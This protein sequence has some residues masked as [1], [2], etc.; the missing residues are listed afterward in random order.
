GQR[1]PRDGTGY[2]ALREW[3]LAGAP[4]RSGPERE[5]QD[6]AVARRG[7]RLRVEAT[8]RSDAGSTVR[9]VTDLALF[10]ST[11]PTVVAVHAEGLL[12][13][14]GPGQP[15]VGAR[16]GT[17]T[18]LLRMVRPF[19]APAVEP[20]AAAHPLDAAWRAH[21]RELGLGPAPPVDAA[22]LARRLHLDLV[23]RP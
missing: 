9:D 22:R 3:L 10:T 8:F 4:W 1:L 12:R 14:V 13:H 7:D 17:H 20:A 6:L 2:A 11:D 19:A 21:L 23:G 16:S 15:P 5:L 18:A